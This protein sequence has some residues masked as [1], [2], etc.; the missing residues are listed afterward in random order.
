MG[1]DSEK[2]KVAPEAKVELNNVN[3]I[4][5]LT[6]A[7][8]GANSG[9][10]YESVRQLALREEIGKIILCCRSQDKADKAIASL[11]KETSKEKD[12]FG[13]VVL[14]LADLGS[15]KAAAEIFPEFDCLV[16]NAGGLAG[17]KAKHEL[18]GATRGQ[19]I[20]TLGHAMLVDMLLSAG[21]IPEGKQVVYIG[22]EV[23]R[24]IWSFQGLLPNYCGNFKEKDIDWAI[25]DNYNSC[26]AARSTLGDYKNA[27]IIGHMHFTNLAK[28]Y[29]NIKWVSTSPGAVGG[30]IFVFIPSRMTFAFT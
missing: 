21:K 18:S 12:F 11:M 16:L 4:P 23:S 9:L 22:S 24:A 30:V 28:D 20:N 14:D 5:K 15:I 19:V 1:P 27:K 29:P 8:T 10:G 25:K 6:V 26:M 7:M 3:P 17:Y 2:A 13:N